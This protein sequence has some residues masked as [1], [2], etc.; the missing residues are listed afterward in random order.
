MSDARDP[1]IASWD[2]A[3]LNALNASQLYCWRMDH[4]LTM[5]QAAAMLGTTRQTISR[6]EAGTMAM[7]GPAARLLTLLHLRV[8]YNLAAVWLGTR[9]E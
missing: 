9:A 6:W 1:E 2:P 7:S 5:D 4:H 3:T 8:V